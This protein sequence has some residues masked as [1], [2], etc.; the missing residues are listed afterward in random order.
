[1]SAFATER[2]VM[3]RDGTELVPEVK[4]PQCGVWGDVDAEQLAGTVSLICPEC[5]WHGYFDAAGAPPG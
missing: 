3:K 4:C 1:M 5:G 2:R